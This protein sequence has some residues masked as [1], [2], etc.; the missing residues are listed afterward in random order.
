M[1]KIKKALDQARK[2]REAG[3]SATT[4]FRGQVEKNL[5]SIRYTQTSS[6]EVSDDILHENR[7][8]NALEQ[9]DYTDSIKMLRTQVLQKMNDNG[10]NVLGVTSAARGEGKTQTVLNLGISIA[11]EM[12]YTVLV[13]DA[14]LRHPSVHE[15]FGIKPA[16][17][18]SDYLS[19]DI[20]LSE[21]LINPKNV[22]HFVILP[23][24]KPMHN[25]AEMLASP[26]MGAMVEEI[27]N[28]YPKRIILFDLPPIIGASDAL[29]FTPYV[30]AVLVT[31]EDGV[32]KESDL[33]TVVDMLSATNVIGTVLNKS[34]R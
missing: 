22:E 24:G 29:A 8:I 2:Q 21:I 30:D 18:L 9:N 19:S 23:G 26:K 13:V 31:V 25:S 28:R 16:Y 20:A 33:K 10:W 1:D 5:E 27:K 3:V 32:T 7:L 12:E 14:N 4:T 11:M 6:V 15:Y 17:G 34:I